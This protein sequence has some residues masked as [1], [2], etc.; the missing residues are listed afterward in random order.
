MIRAARLLNLRRI[1]H[2]PVRA[3][4]AVLAVAGGV[5]L[6]TSLLVV[7]KSFTDS[8][9][10]F[11]RALGGPAPLRVVGATARGGLDEGVLGAVQR[12][13]GVAVAVPVV[14][15]ITYA[16]GAAARARDVT[17]LALG[18][19]CRI[20]AFVGSFGCSQEAITGARDSDPPIVSPSLVRRLGTNGQLLTDAGRIPLD[21]APMSDRLERTPNVASVAVFPLPVAQKL[22]ARPHRLD[23]IY[24]KPAPGADIDALKGRLEA[25]V[26]GWN[27]VLATTDPPPGAT[28]ILGGFLPLFGM[29]AVFGIGVAVVLV[30]DTVALSVEERRRDLAVVAALGGEGRTVVG[31]TV[32]EAA[33]LG[34]VGGILGAAGALPLGSSIL[35]SLSRFSERFTGVHLSVHAG[36]MPFVVGALLGTLIASVAAWI[37][38]RRAMR[39]DV[40]AE[41]SNRGLRDE[42]APVLRLRRALLFTAVG[43][44]AL[45]LCWVA[46]RQGA[47]AKWQPPAGQLGVGVAS[48][49]F[50]IAS[51][52]FAPLVLALALRARRGT[53]APTRL[54]LANLVRDP[55]RT[56][57]MAA[58]VGAPIGIAFIIASFILSIHD[59]VTHNVTKNAAGYVRAS[60]LPVN[61]AINLD[62]GLSPETL[63]VL[64]RLPGVARI[65]RG[66]AVLAGH[67]SGELIGVKA[68]ENEDRFTFAV[69]RGT[70]DPARFARGEVLVG[71]GLA[72]RLDL[73]AGSRLRL[74]TPTGWG[75]V[76]VQG[77]WDDGDFN[78]NSVSMPL[79]MLERLYGPQPVQSA[80]LKLAPGASA[81]QVRSAVYAAK[82]DPAMTAQTPAE[83]AQQISTD[84]KTT[85]TSFYA[86]QRALLLVAFVAVLATLLLAAV[87]RRRELAL[88]SA[89]G[90]RPSELGRMVLLEAVA[91]GIVGT[92]LGTIFGVGM[93]AAL[94]LVLP[95]FIGFH[96]PFR[97]DLSS[98]PA[99]AL[100]VT[101][102]V[103]LAAAWPAWRTARVEVVENLQ[104][105]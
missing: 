50:I 89:V 60:T 90:M 55:G 2:Q 69:F 14:Q 26:G 94:H 76:T 12:T 81:D 62:A 71:A 23:A 58:A 82:L 100:L 29:L 25:A 19:D 97:L 70:K 9:A 102:I 83:L 86:I 54:G 49:A 87:Q 61:N 47:L 11:G 35:A 3:V 79:P 57:T 105:E 18:V 96:D 93:Y 1:K 91:V 45:M 38:A 95:V 48:A 42:N 101:L 104:Y 5:A 59:S 36:A 41:L 75:D 43:V 65:D 78:A 4:L 8:Y 85:F 56:G 80:A 16:D 39:M 7:Q 73:H 24:V 20:E 64:G 72:R 66:A 13:P 30:Y 44:A 6:G 68:F 46:Q 74:P 40:A 103:V 77:V 32:A 63:A 21:G 99:T 53:R 37:P 33:V 31:G 98:V 17:V 10:A 67:K 51:G 92:V 15:A 28:V 84:I 27:G 52:A 22:F 34:L 88:L